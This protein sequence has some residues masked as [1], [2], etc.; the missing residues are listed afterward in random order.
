[1]GS[2]VVGIVLVLLVAFAPTF[3]VA[4]ILH[5]EK[6]KYRAKADEPF[7]QLPLRPPGESLRL[8][9]ETLSE[10]FDANFFGL[11][12]SAMLAGALLWK[13]P[14]TILNWETVVLIVICGNFY[15][16]RKLVRLARE[17]W[18]YRLA[19]A[20]ERVVGEELNQL[21]AFGF[22]VFHD[23]PFDNFNI[24]HVMVG[25]P[26]VYAVETKTRRK[27]ADIKGLDSAKV[28]FDGAVLHFPKYTDSTAVIQ[29]RR[30]AETLSKWL[31][32]ATGESVSASAIVTLPGWFVERR[33]RSD[34]NVLNPDEIKRSFP[35]PAAPLSPEQIQRIS[36]QLTERCR[37]QKS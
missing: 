14:W 13:L 35:R 3:F 15:F 6:K 23:L 34:V 9:I 17:L 30:N 24:D 22:R 29:A 19:F 7:T 16:G 4:S 20:G 33:A 21:L 11:A 26:G 32:S 37:M 8:K 10:E 27:P 31:T 18:K 2:R 28:V 25:P 5:R 36:H 12:L 1:M